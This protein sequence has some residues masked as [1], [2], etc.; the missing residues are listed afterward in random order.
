MIITA[1]Q[2]YNKISRYDNFVSYKSINKAYNLNIEFYDFS[3]KNKR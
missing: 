1:S 3:K 2:L